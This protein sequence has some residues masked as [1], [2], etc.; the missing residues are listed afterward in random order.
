MTKTTRRIAVMSFSGSPSAWSEK[1]M[2][3]IADAYQQDTDRYKQRQS[4]TGLV[5]SEHMRL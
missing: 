2:L 1:T 4:L 5:A 3:V